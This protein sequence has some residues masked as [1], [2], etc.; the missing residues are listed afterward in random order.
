MGGMARIAVA[1]IIL[2]Q[3]QVIASVRQGEA[4]GMAEH[5]RMDMA[6]ACPRCSDGDDPVDGLSG[7]GLTALGD[8]QPGKEI[9]PQGEPATKGTKFVAGNRLLDRQ[10]IL[11]PRNPKPGLGKIDIVAS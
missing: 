6:K 3:A 1:K 7:Q 10:S 5:M 11:E 4:T 8:K 2:D 9:L